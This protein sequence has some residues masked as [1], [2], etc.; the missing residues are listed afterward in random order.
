M[1]MVYAVGFAFS[2]LLVVIY[3]PFLQPVFHT[4]PLGLK[5]WTVV[6]GLSTLPLIVGELGKLKKVN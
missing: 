1:T 2:L 5:E 4:F 6:L 3:I